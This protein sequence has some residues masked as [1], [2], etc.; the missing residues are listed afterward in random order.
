ME[1]RDTSILDMNDRFKTLLACVER[2][3]LDVSV[4]LVGDGTLFD[5]FPPTVDKVY[6]S[7]TSPSDCD[8]I[9]LVILQ[10][11]CCAF[12]TLFNIL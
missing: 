6:S 12:S 2:W 5:D 4:L 10:V 1:S 9:I 3:S 8:D 11:L 7:L